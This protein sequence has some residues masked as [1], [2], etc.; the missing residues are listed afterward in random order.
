MREKRQ[1][2]GHGCTAA[3]CALAAAVIRQLLEKCPSRRVEGLLP[4]VKSR[5]VSTGSL[6]GSSPG[7]R[8]GE[9]DGDR[10]RAMIGTRKVLTVS[11][12]HQYHSRYFLSAQ[13]ARSE[14]FLSNLCREG[15]FVWKT[16]KCENH[17]IHYSRNPPPIIVNVRNTGCLSA[18]NRYSLAGV[19]GYQKQL[20]PS[21]MTSSQGCFLSD[22]LSQSLSCFG[23][24]N[25]LLQK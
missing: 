24:E 4:P 8:L 20:L 16:R 11:R 22:E 7:R 9:I 21:I 13:P 5:A 25:S 18:R 1:A 19:M 6:T 3:C 12:N 23:K 2:W 15:R 17:P 10:V 14:V